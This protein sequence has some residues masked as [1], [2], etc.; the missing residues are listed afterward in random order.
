M[1]KLSISIAA[2][3]ACCSSMGKTSMTHS[4]NDAT[5]SKIHALPSSPEY[6]P[7]SAA[8]DTLFNHSKAPSTI[9]NNFLDALCGSRF[10]HNLITSITFARSVIHC[11]FNSSNVSNASSHCSLSLVMFVPV[12]SM[13]PAKPPPARSQETQYSSKAGTAPGGRIFKAAK[14]VG[15][16][17]NA[18]FIDEVVVACPF[19]GTVAPFARNNAVHAHNTVSNDFKLGI[20]TNMANR[21]S[22]ATTNSS[23]C[24]C[25]C[26]CSP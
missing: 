3:D 21:S 1:T 10:A 19:F 4:V 2:L 25:F 7:P 11:I 16:D 6:P 12:G 24:C 23:C 22:K 13:P 26:C 14:V 8:V 5:P 17:D 20:R 18:G 15:D 9:S